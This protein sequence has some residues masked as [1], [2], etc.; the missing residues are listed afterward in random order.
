MSW[1]LEKFAQ[2]YLALREDGYP[3]DEAADIAAVLVRIGE[4]LWFQTEA[5]RGIAEIPITTGGLHD[6]C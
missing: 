3:S 2:H 5:E 1:P 4:Q 6:G